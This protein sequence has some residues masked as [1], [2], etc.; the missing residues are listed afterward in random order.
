MRI[1]TPKTMLPVRETIQNS[2]DGI[3]SVECRSISFDPTRIHTRARW[4]AAHTEQPSTIIQS[5]KQQLVPLALCLFLKTCSTHTHSL[6][7]AIHI[8]SDSEI[9]HVYTVVY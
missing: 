3:L 9:S 1:Q 2:L 7:Q 8:L 6:E 5:S 4:D